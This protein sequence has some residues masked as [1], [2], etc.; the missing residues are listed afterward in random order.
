MIFI[1]PFVYYQENYVFLQK[2]YMLM[3]TSVNPTVY[4]RELKG[5]IIEVAMREFKQKGVR[6]VKMDDI[7]RIL[8][9][10][11]RTLY[12]IYSDKQE[13]LLEGVRL[14]EQRRDEQMFSFANEKGKGAID[15]IVE[16]YRM[17]IKNL[18]NVNPVFFEDVKK[19][20]KVWDYIHERHLIHQQNGLQFL[21]RGVED[22]F[23]RDDVDYVLIS[24]LAEDISRFV[25]DSHMYTKYS[26]EHVFR[27]IIF[28]FFRGFS[29]PKGI[30]EMDR[31]L[32][33]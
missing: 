8:S 4:R 33:K 27:N 13:L 11:K 6:S 29:T 5:R 16:F 22:G 3:R 24:Q 15:I 28:L 14:E 32:T 7:A 1:Q 12:E 26:L 21:K 31:L 10:S 9:I 20:K 23:F 30:E 19:Y 17:Q 18:A 2:K 25:I